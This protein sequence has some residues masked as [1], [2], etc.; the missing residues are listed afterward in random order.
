MSHLVSYGKR[1]CELA[2]AMPRLPA[3]VLVAENGTERTVTW[4]ELDSR[5]NRVARL[6][7]DHGVDEGALV[8]IGLPNGVEHY[9]VSLATWKLGACVL[10]LNARMPPRE[11]DE[12]LAL[13]PGA[14]VVADWDLEAR[15]CI[16]SA[17]IRS[18]DHTDDPLPDRV[19]DPGKACT[20]GGS[21]G[22]PKIIV[23]PGPW[24]GVPGHIWDGL[25][26]AVGLRAVQT[27]LV[28]G[29]L[30]YNGPFSWSH[31]GLFEGHR[32]IVLEHFDAR[33]ALDCIARFG[34]NFMFT[35]P[36]M[37][38]RMQRDATPEDDL[39]SVESIFH[40]GAACPSWLKRWWI[41]RVGGKHIWEAYGASEA[42][43]TTILRGDEWLQWPGSVGRPF[44]SEVRI[45]DEDGK[46]V[47]PGRIGEIFMRPLYGDGS[48]YIG[49]PPLRSVDGLLTVGDLGWM[50]EDGYLYL[51]DR[52]VDMIVSG[53]VNV[54]PAEVEGAV[55][56]HRDVADVAVIGLPDAEWGRRVH[57]IIESRDPRN[58]PS[59]QSLREHCRDRLA[60]YKVPKSW[61]FV[62]RLP[63]DE[64]L[65]LRRSALVSEREP[66]DMRH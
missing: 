30:Y 6:L 21:T 31:F 24:A 35:V 17:R 61:E 41:E 38:L 11:R 13:V 50:N 14:V 28:L 54:F 10:L 3:I 53:G 37:L 59:A 51:A 65:K 36:T 5:S 49:S 44:K 60:A 43:G 32:L 9:E 57:A 27:Q 1:L 15:A 22:R 12:I 20:S 63:R 18:C 7:A 25:P 45:L 46:P 4:A 8:A 62:D 42:I 23:Q 29:S 40:A 58:P 56:E 33:M 16:P 2:T 66:A 64:N 47:A 52:R 19:P 55:L 26:A 39:S 34:V 48:Y